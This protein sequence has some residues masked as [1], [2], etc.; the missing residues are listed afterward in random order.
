[1]KENNETTSE[2]YTTQGHSVE[3]RRNE[4]KEEL[5]IDGVRRKFFVN[6]DG[7]TL[8]EA[9]FDRPYKS[10]REAVEHYLEKYPNQ[11]DHH[12]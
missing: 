2:K 9:A 11:T 7:Y 5:W 6:K 3:I 12:H 8:H 1:M 10:L 4:N